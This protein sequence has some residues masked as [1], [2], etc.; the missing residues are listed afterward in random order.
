[1]ERGRA[2]INSNNNFDILPSYD[3][4]ENQYASN[5]LP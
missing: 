5:P 4:I 1:M 2:L 3:N